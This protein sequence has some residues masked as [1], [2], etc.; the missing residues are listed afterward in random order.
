[1]ATADDAIHDEG[2]SVDERAKADIFRA[3]TPFESVPILRSVRSGVS[4]SSRAAHSR[5]RTVALSIIGLGIVALLM[6]AVTRGNLLAGSARGSGAASSTPTPTSL[7][8]GGASPPRRM[9]KAVVAAARRRYGV[10]VQSMTHASDAASIL[11]SAETGPILRNNLRTIA[12]LRRLAQ[13]YSIQQHTWQVKWVRLGLP[14]HATVYV[15]GN[16]RRELEADAGVIKCFEGTYQEL[17]NM[18]QLAGTWKTETRTVRLGQGRCPGGTTAPPPTST[19]VKD[20]SSAVMAAVLRYWQLWNH[21]VQNNDTSQI[22]Q[23]AVSPWLDHLQG[24]IGNNRA[25]GIVWRTANTK[26]PIVGEPTFVDTTRA[27]VRFT[28]YWR[29]EPTTVSTGHPATNTGDNQSGDAP[30]TVLYTLV[31]D[32]GRWYISNSANQ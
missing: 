2:E 9:E 8:A 6:L 23:I 1:M 32:Q 29:I 26:P 15:V 16:D 30:Q 27:T 11:E 12:R 21:E 14:G 18:V 28:R 5:L 31:L 3:R 25:L 4:G 22:T 19:P 13:K 24:I 10:W 7:A 17:Y 20:A